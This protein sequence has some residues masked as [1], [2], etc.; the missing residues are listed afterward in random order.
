M[1]E[2]D[3]I[4]EAAHFL[5]RINGAD[6]STIQFEVS[7]FLSA[8]RSALQYAHKEASGKPGGQ[9][10]Y[11]R[12]VTTA[13]GVVGFLS[14][15]RNQNVHAQP[16]HMRT[17]TSVL[18]QSSTLA[19]TGTLSAVHIDGKTGA[20]TEFHFDNTSAPPPADSSPRTVPKTTLSHRYSFRNWTGPE[21]ASNLCARYLTEIQ[22]IVLDGQKQGFL[23]P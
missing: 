4:D 2:Q 18:M 22:R 3:K 1:H 20:R 17:D 8:A 5:A 21:D 9:A 7:A 10:W 14:D 15:E 6:I 23:T 16:L 19:M 11:D 12:S 13:D